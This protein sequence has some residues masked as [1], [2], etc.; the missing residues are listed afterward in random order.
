M[1]LER[2]AANSSNFC[3]KN[4]EQHVPQRNMQVSVRICEKEERTNTILL[5]LMELN[6][7]RLER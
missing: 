3:S 4:D 7:L 1:N 5:I 2:A 6:N